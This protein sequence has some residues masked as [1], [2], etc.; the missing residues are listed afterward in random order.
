MYSLKSVPLCA[1]WT[2]VV[3]KPGLA[4]KLSGPVL[5]LMV[6]VIPCFV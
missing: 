6:T 2:A 3:L 1:A 4:E 5:L